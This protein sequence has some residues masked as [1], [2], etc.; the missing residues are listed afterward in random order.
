M[1]GLDGDPGYPGAQGDPGIEGA[2]GEEGMP[3][4]D[5]PD[6][7]MGEPGPDGENGLNG[8]D[9]KKATCT[10]ENCKPSKPSCRETKPSPKMG[11]L[12]CPTGQYMRGLRMNSSK[13]YIIDCCSLF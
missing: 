6:G 5:G 10:A 1:D 4:P 9:G 11:N 7:E 2:K 8:V 3:G 13:N 12:K